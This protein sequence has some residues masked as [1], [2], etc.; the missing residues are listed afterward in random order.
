[1]SRFV[2]KM[3]RFEL[4]KIQMFR[5]SLLCDLGVIVRVVLSPSPLCQG[6]DDFVPGLAAAFICLPKHMQITDWFSCS[7]VRNT[8]V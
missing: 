7:S 5:T 2:V 6:F 1:M 4:L 8:S 3:S